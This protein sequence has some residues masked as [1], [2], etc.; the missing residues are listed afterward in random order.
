MRGDVKQRSTKEARRERLLP[1]LRGRCSPSQR[2][3]AHRELA[4]PVPPRRRARALDRPWP[5]VI[6]PV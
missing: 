1:D 4:P 5:P 2:R 3:R 6:G